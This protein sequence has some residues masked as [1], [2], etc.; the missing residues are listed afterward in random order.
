MQL[1]VD[2]VR[3]RSTRSIEQIMIDQVV[4]Y[5]DGLGICTTVACLMHA[6]TDAARIFIFEQRMAQDM[7]KADLYAYDSDMGHHDDYDN[8]HP[9]ASCEETC[10]MDMQTIRFDSNNAAEEFMDDCMMTCK[11]EMGHKAEFDLSAFDGHYEN[12]AYEE[13]N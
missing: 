10:M 8:Y 4:N 1:A 6:A 5:K 13:H 11:E 3:A 9:K 7:K 12:V 2:E